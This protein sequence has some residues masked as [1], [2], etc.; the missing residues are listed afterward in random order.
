MS[1]FGLSKVSKIDFST[2]W[3]SVALTFLI[4]QSMNDVKCLA[5]FES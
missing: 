5:W 4:V 2:I 3:N 1:P